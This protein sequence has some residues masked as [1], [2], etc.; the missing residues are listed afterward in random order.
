MSQQPFSTAA[1][2]GAVDL[3]AI[4]AAG[5]RKAAAAAGGPANGGGYVVEVTE[6]E[7]QS[8]VIERSMTVPVIVDLWTARAAQSQQISSVLDTLA[9]EYAGRFLVARVDI[10]TNPALVQAF[11]VQTLPFVVAVIKG[12]PLPLIADVLPESAVRQVL[13]KLLEV[14]AQNGV[15]GRA[16]G[17]VASDVEG[18]GDEAGGSTAPTAPSAPVEPAL[19]PLHQQA[20]DAI[21]RDDLDAAAAAYEQAL[22][23]NPADDLASVGLVNVQLMQRVSGL[24]ADAAVTAADAA[25]DDTAAQLRAADAE[26]VTGQVEAAFSRLVEAVR[27]RTGDE[28][29]LVRSRLVDLFALLGPDDPQVRRARIALT[30][31]LF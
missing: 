27:V 14:A 20:Y 8:A 31:A 1:L 9:A 6:Q 24:D 11:Q 21:E 2:R 4:A 28:R 30:N 23:E 7:F 3:G 29:E 26:F 13:D 16:A 12:Q 17:D 19:P 25:P 5:Q 22:R 15:T 10:D 18:G